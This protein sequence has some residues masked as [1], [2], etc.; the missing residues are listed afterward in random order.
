MIV[1]YTFLNQVLRSADRTVKVRNIIDGPLGL[2][3]AGAW[4]TS[5]FRTFP[6]RDSVE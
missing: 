3:P 1:P 4:N 5:A 2:R 6:D